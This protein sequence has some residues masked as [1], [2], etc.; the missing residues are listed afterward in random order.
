MS[1]EPNRDGTQ[2]T[3]AQEVALPKPTFTGTSE[4]QRSE[5]D[6]LEK[7]GALLDERLEKQRREF[8]SIIDKR[9]AKVESPPESVRSVAEY[10]R[11]V[12]EGYSERE[13]EMQM[14][15]DRLE[16]PAAQSVPGRTVE[17]GSSTDSQFDAAKFLLDNKFDTNSPDVLRL[18]S[19]RYADPNEFKAA[20]F[21]LQVRKLTAPPPSASAAPATAGGGGRVGVSDDD[22]RKLYD[23]LSKLQL[24][25]SRNRAEIEEISKQLREAGHP[26][27]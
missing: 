10:K 16:Q 14:R 20:A 3:P 11:L 19:G 21:E 7:I 4:V 18:L 26:V 13:A 23:R 25:P 22:A 24:I 2:D 1:D 27:D 5:A 9:L 8:Q 6:P 12:A 17:G 15:L